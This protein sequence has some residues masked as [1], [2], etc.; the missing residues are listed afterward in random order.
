MAAEE[1]V[2]SVEIP[3]YHFIGPSS[4]RARSE[5]YQ[6]VGLP[7]SR[8]DLKQ[9]VD[10]LRATKAFGTS[11]DSALVWWMTSSELFSPVDFH[12]LAGAF[13]EGSQ[14]AKSDQADTALDVVTSY[15]HEQLSQEHPDGDSSP[16][17]RTLTVHA[18][19]AIE[20]PDTYHPDVAE[21]LLGF[22]RNKL[23]RKVRGILTPDQNYT[24]WKFAT[25]ELLHTY[26]ELD[27]RQN[28]IQTYSPEQRVLMENIGL[29]GKAVKYRDFLDSART[30]ILDAV[31][32]LIGLPDGADRD[33]KQRDGI[34]AIAQ[35]LQMAHQMP[36][37]RPDGTV[38]MVSEPMYSYDEYPILI[39]LE[40]QV[41]ELV[42]KRP[43]DGELVRAYLSL[44]H[45]IRAGYHHMKERIARLGAAL[46][47][48]TVAEDLHYIYPYDT[49]AGY[50]LYVPERRTGS[51]ATVLAEDIEQLIDSRLHGYGPGAWYGPS[52][53]E[54]WGYADGTVRDEESLLAEA[55]PFVDL[56]LDSADKIPGDVMEELVHVARRA[57]LNLR[58][59]AQA[60]PKIVEQKKKEKFPGP[61]VRALQ[62]FF[63]YV[64]K[65][66]SKTP[67]PL[68]PKTVARDSGV[69]DDETVE[70]DIYSFADVVRDQDIA[71]LRQA[72]G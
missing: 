23:L 52:T 13:L 64:E 31:P 25:R 34:L 8:K 30:R 4:A 36:S 27:E 37:L 43:F 5:A 71:F 53:E 32:F 3:P 49:A 21:I 69:W 67:R 7:Q 61:S 62:F 42:G 15:L 2:A 63:A 10:K 38:R 57:G 56:L 11:P 29:G 58:T 19:D 65:Y 50:G 22:T 16:L 44:P 51:I 66:G 12:A 24:F 18:L 68:G 40:Q 54:A 35:A 20:H 72:S 1:V 41:E 6:Y 33:E 70:V 47:N 45:T 26:L 60:V 55:W 46:S 17:V 59:I 14:V 39:A 28:L 48:P 9:A